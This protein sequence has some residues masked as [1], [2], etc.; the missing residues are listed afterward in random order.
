MVCEILIQYFTQNLFIFSVNS[1]Q[2]D[3]LIT[4]ET[5]IDYVLIYKKYM[6][7]TLKLN[8]VLLL[9]HFL[10]NISTANIEKVVSMLFSRRRSNTDEYTLAQF[11]Y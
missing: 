11:S 3:L 4:D 10:V 9:S 5:I 7:Y 8:F 6:F 2:Y 1:I